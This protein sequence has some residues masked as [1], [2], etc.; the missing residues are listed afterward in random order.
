MVTSKRFHE[1]KW[2]STGV[3]G[4]SLCI[5]GTGL[6]FLLQGV[7]VRA[8]TWTSRYDN[9]G[10][11]MLIWYTDEGAVPHTA[12]HPVQE[13]KEAILNQYPETAYYDDR[14]PDQD[15]VFPFPQ[16]PDVLCTTAAPS[17]F[18]LQGLWS[19]YSVCVCCLVLFLGWCA[20]DTPVAFF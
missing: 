13:H 9:D 17:R 2:V 14:N 20:N 1:H 12:P 3:I 15:R 10:T 7:R 8:A 5:I 19:R 4:V 11:L 6:Y 16:T 18:R